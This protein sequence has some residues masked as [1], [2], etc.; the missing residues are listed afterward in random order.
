MS[1]IFE[2]ATNKNVLQWECKSCHQPIDEHETVAYHLVSGI[3]YGWC[4]DCF[5]QREP[6]NKT[7]SELSAVAAL[8]GPGV[9]AA[10]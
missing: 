6:V 8:S 9:S 1:A 10:A 7:I 5:S 3:L 4:P 2:R